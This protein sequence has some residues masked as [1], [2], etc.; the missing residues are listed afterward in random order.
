M[1]KKEVDKNIKALKKALGEN[2]IRKSQNQKTFSNVTENITKG[3][4]KKS[5]LKAFTRKEATI[6]NKNIRKL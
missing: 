5:V 1:E 4:N 3:E 6:F 2:L